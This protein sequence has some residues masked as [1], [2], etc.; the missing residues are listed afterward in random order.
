[1]TQS[2]IPVQ[3]GDKYVV[4]DNVCS[5]NNPMHSR[6]ICA[7]EEFAQAIPRARELLRTKLHLHQTQNTWPTLVKAV[8]SIQKPY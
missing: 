8:P 7:P 2:M 5:L 1:M 6:S 3:A 4:R